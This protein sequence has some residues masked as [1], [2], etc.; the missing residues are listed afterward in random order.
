MVWPGKKVLYCVHMVLQSEEVYSWKIF[1]FA[2]FFNDY[3][4]LCKIEHLCCTLKT[5]IFIKTINFLLP[6]AESLIWLMNDFCD[7]WRKN[8]CPKASNT[9]LS[10]YNHQNVAM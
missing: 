1:K 8:S 3:P 5:C 2:L 9:K 7:R 6:W 10:W 4:T